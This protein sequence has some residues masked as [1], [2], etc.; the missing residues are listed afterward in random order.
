MTFPETIEMCKQLDATYYAEAQR[1]PTFIIE[2]VAYQRSL[3][4]QLE[5]KVTQL[6]ARSSKHE[7]PPCHL[8]VTSE[9]YVQ[10]AET[11]PPIGATA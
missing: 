4:Q 8:K 6:N 7:Q 2:D 11:S 10:G 1:H 5:T 3:P 9:W